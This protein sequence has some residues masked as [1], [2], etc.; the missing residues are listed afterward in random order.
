[1]ADGH[2]SLNSARAMCGSRAKKPDV[3]APANQNTP[4]TRRLETRDLDTR[5]S[6]LPLSLK[7]AKKIQSRYREIA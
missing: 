1:M 4:Y 6:S 5:K 3:M 7:Y 2:A